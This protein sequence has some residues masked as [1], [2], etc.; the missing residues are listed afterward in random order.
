MNAAEDLPGRC[1]ACDHRKTRRLPH[2]CHS[3]HRQITGL[4]RRKGAGVEVLRTI[5]DGIAWFQGLN[6]WL[7]AAG[8]S[9]V[10]YVAYRKTK[11]LDRNAV[12]NT[13]ATIV[14]SVFNIATAILLNDR[15]YSFAQRCYDALGIPTLPPDFWADTNI[16]VATAVALAARDLCDY[17]IH[18]AMHTKW[19]WPTHAAHHSD[20]HVNAFTAYRVHYLEAVVMML[21]YMVLLTWL[22]LPDYIPV[23]AVLVAV[24]NM[25]VHLDLPYTHGPLKYLIAS[26]VF[27][28][29]HHADV[30]EAHGKNLANIMPIYDVI[31]GTYHLPGPCQEKL[32]AA[33]SGI[34]D[35]NPVLIWIYP[36]QQWARLIRE[37]AGKLAVRQKRRED[38][39]YPQGLPP[40]D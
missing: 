27:H 34:S 19:G 5:A 33:D 7:I 21:N 31:F 18:R 23:V 17:A 6:G 16:F 1:S 22:Q 10:L 4:N 25:Y 28:R 35:K 9:L 15:I 14:L 24:H 29:W 20:T 26:P 13:A 38:A 30:P 3:P 8:M 39:P 40:A 37:A 2:D 32:G 12:E 36:F 11:E